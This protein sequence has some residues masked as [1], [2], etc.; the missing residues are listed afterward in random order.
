MSDHAFVNT[1]TTSLL[2]ITTSRLPLRNSVAVRAQ[3]G[4][5][6]TVVIAQHRPAP[7]PKIRSLAWA[8][9]PAQIFYKNDPP[10][11]IPSR[12]NVKRNRLTFRKDSDIMVGMMEGFAD[13]SWCLRP[14]G[15]YLLL[16]RGKVVYAGQTTNIAQRLYTHCNRLQRARAG[17]P[18]LFHEHPA[19]EFDE[20]K[21]KFVP[22]RDLDK[23]ELALIQRYLPERN[24]LLKRPSAGMDLSGF[25]F[26][27]KLSTMADEGEAAYAEVKLKRRKLPNHI[28]KLEGQFQRGRD[29]QLKISLHRIKSLE[30]GKAA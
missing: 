5:A 25:E 19:V 1:L 14:C 13:F 8:N 10:I 23:E 4:L 22:E 26:F 24:K 7:T 18:K 16:L 11:P 15:V 29:R 12:K 27:Q 21:V 2:P 9:G 30:D 6:A 28:R 20:V 3:C 17:K